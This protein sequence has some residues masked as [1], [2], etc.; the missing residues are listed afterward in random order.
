[1]ELDCAPL[2][3]LKD[4]SVLLE[5]VREGLALLT[6]EQD[7]FAYA[8]SFD[9][10]AGRYR[11]LRFARHVSLNEADAPGLLVRPAVARQQIDAE[12]LPPPPPPPPGNGKNGP[13]PFPPPPPP[14]PRPDRTQ[15]KRY[16]GTVELDPA[17]VGRDA[18]RIADEVIAHLVGLV[19][20]NVR[21]TL[22]IEAELPDGVPEQVVRVV[23]EN[24]RTLRFTSHGFELE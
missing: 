5:A 11:G 9:E 21:V 24:G 22:E 20:A 14:P 8:E 23:T 10:T 15:P 13:D 4:A 17:R 2:P 7:A 3:R 18:G 16:H 1:M 19:R 6:W 12:T